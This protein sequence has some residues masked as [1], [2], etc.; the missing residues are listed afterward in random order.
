V[1]S[2]IETWGYLVGPLIFMAITVP[3]F[4]RSHGRE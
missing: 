1:I 2:P 3:L 4:T